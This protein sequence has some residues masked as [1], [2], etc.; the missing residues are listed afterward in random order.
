VVARERDVAQV[1]GLL[2][3]L[4]PPRH[5]DNSLLALPP[6]VEKNPCPTLRQIRAKGW[7]TP[8]LVAIDPLRLFTLLSGTA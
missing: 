7:A 8:V 3:A 6:P 4:K 5:G 1:S 2:E